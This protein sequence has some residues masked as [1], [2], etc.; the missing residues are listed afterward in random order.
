M[1]NG[2]RGAAGA[3]RAL[4][5]RRLRHG[6]DAEHTLQIDNMNIIINQ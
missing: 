6:E 2:H 3:A 1:Y 4:G 5:A